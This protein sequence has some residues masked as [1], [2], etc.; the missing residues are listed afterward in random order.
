VPNYTYNCFI[1][2]R[3][4]RGDKCNKIAFTLTSPTPIQM[5]QKLTLPVQFRKKDGQTMTIYPSFKVAELESWILPVDSLKFL[6]DDMRATFETSRVSNIRLV[7][8]SRQLKKSIE[9]VKK[10]VH[11]TGASLR[12]TLL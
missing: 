1:E 3:A 8:I 11:A 6:S 7:P 4:N 2:A 10:F 12:S 5:G 9:R